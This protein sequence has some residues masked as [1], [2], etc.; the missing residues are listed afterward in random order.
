MTK[1]QTK[2]VVVVAMAGVV[3]LGCV[4]DDPADPGLMTQQQAIS[5]CGGFAADGTVGDPEDY[6]DDYCAAEV[7]AWTYDPQTETL[8]LTDA[9]ALLNCCGARTIEMRLVD[10]VYVV[11]ETDGPDEF[12]RCLCMCVFDLRLTVEGMPEGAIPVRLERTVTDEPSGT[13][14]L[15]EGTLDLALGAGEVVIDGRSAEGWCGVEI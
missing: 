9:R 4:E 5:D 14:V 6:D 2:M 15:W 10:D 8:V 11:S 1:F 3:G 7:L 12:G 13:T